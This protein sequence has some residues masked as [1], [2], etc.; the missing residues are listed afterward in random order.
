MKVALPTLENDI[1]IIDD[2]SSLLFSKEALKN[3]QATAVD[4]SAKKIKSADVEAC[5][6]Q[7]VDFTESALEKF[8]I[9]DTFIDSGS[10]V[11]CNFTESGWR[12]VVVSNARCS[13]TLFQ[14]S[15]LKDVVFRDCKLDL[16]NFRYAK[17][18]NVLFD[19]CLLNDTDFYNAELT[20]VTFDGCT[21]EKIELS[22]AKLKKVD[23]SSSELEIVQGIT[24]MKGAIVSSLQ[25]IS[26][27]PYLAN[28]LG[29]VVKYDE[30]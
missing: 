17:L 27:A 7:K 22:S 2:A 12:Y 6:L 16:T 28:E 18:E 5:R 11:A 30:T 20:N 14:M 10:L 25:L 8:V 1:D 4:I 3:I 15:K 13:G 29:L 9:K 21:I 24:S 19:N 26:L 23:F